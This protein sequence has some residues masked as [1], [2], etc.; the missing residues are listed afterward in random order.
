MSPRTRCLLLLAFLSAAAQA[1]TPPPLPTTV[2]DTVV[3]SGKQPGPGLWKVSK[4]DHVM[5]VLGTISP[6]PK[7]MQWASK[8]VEETVADSQ[9]LLLPPSA[10]MKV[11]GAVLGGIFLIPSLMKARNNPEDKRLADVLP[12]QDYAR[13][14]RLKQKYMG[15][16]RGVEK[17]RPMMAAAELQDEALDDEDLSTR[18]IAQQVAERTAKKHDLAITTPSV[19][20]VIKDAKQ[21]LRDFRDTPMQD[22]ECFRLTLDRVEHNIESMK[23]RANAWALGEV[24]IL[25]SLP[26]TDNF[27]A[28]IDAIIETRIAKESGL[29]DLDAKLT[30]AWMDAA[31]KALAQNESTFAVLPMSLMLREGGFL[32]QLE[33]RGYTVE[34]PGDANDE[35][36]PEATTT[37]TESQAASIDPAG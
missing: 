31:D 14:Q 26:Y 5:W 10:S 1:D 36:A 12:S 6:L 9:E 18:N 11:E 2:L 22:L 15:R 28:C 8:E 13:W 21:L 37:T 27:R 33:A 20:F 24:E 25:R 19:K 3:V 30:G 35:N 7:R 34:A 29:D 32:S 17:R 16:D 4:D 23:L